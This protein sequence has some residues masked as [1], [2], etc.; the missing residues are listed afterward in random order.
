MASRYVSLVRKLAKKQEEGRLD[1]KETETD[2]QFQVSF[3]DYGLR[4]FQRSGRGGS[5]D[6]IIA[7]YDAE[8]SVIDEFSDEDI[9]AEMENSYQV[10]SSL[11]GAA[12]RSALGVEKALQNILNELDEEPY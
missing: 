1:W 7:I 5:T 6:I 10:M 2:G 3:S 11:F 4:I 8:G 9:K 12:R